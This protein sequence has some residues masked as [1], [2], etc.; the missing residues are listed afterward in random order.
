M[1]A[2]LD[3]REFC[4]LGSS[5]APGRTYLVMI[6]SLFCRELVELQERYKL[7][8]KELKDA[9]SQ[10]KMA[11]GEFAEVNDRLSEMRTAKQGLSRQV[12]RGAHGL[13]SPDGG[14]LLV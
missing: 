7:Q 4:Y 5:L 11:M 2:S 9:V 3:P 10:R 8:S 14:E 13:L 12:R 1:S 6:H